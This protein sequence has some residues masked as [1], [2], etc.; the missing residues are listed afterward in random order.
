MCLFQIKTQAQNMRE[1]HKLD[2]YRLANNL[3]IPYNKI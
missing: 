1:K 3:K 2:I